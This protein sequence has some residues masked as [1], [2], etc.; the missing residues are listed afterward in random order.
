MGNINKKKFFFCW[1]V[2]YNQKGQ[3]IFKKR[4][5]KSNL[6]VFYRS[7]VKGS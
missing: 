5:I 3:I 1:E 7:V 6:F 2:V 4:F